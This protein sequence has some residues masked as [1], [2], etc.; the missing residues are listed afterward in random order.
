MLGS[1]TTNSG[2]MS[3]KASYFSGTT[4]VIS[5]TWESRQKRN[6][7]MLVECFDE[8]YVFQLVCISGYDAGFI[9]CFITD[10]PDVVNAHAVTYDHLYRRLEFLFG[11]EITVEVIPDSARPDVTQPDSDRIVAEATPSRS[12][13]L[14]P[15]DGSVIS[16]KDLYWKGTTFVISYTWESERRREEHMLVENFEEGYVFQIICTSGY[17]AGYTRGFITDDPEVLNARAVTYDHLCRRLEFHFG[18]GV[19]LEA[20][21]E[22]PEAERPDPT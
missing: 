20:I 6:E 15:V 8:G 22:R 13:R 16:E 3:D 12:G 11:E 18:E 9:P 19:T 4:F 14:H 7:Y 17:Y 2:T 5:Y 1:I 10:D 21:Y